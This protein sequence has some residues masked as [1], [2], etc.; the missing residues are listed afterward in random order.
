VSDVRECPADMRD[1]S[2][3]SCD[4]PWAARERVLRWRGTRH[5]GR[6]E[7]AST[8]GKSGD[9][10]T[11]ES[12]ENPELVRIERNAERARA[13]GLAA[14][15]E[16]LRIGKRVEDLRQELDRCAADVDRP[17]VPLPSQWARWPVRLGVVIIA[18]AL[19]G[20][21]AVF[22]SGSTSPQA[23]PAKGIPEQVAAPGEMLSADAITQP[24]HEPEPSHQQT[25]ADRNLH[26][27][28]AADQEQTVSE[29][30]PEPTRTASASTL[31]TPAVSPVSEPTQSASALSASVPIACLPSELIDVLRDV[32]ARFG[33]V[34]LVSTTHLHTD[35]HSR[36]STRHKLHTGCKAV[37]FKVK[38]DVKAVTAYLRSRPEVA[39][40]NSFRNNGVIHIDHNE[41]RKIG[42]R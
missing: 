29:A 13:A 15:Q 8:S 3:V 4:E 12:R 23:E 21:A 35:N 5:I 22:F 34:T 42:K 32:E 14:V 38:A 36:G 27:T 39:G 11:R 9:A 10:M 19:G 31:P 16:V 1:M 24:A 20:M 18:A 41:Y 7:T 30:D 28:A 37:D 17:S 6:Q 26:S 25:S 33:P 40:I 2:V